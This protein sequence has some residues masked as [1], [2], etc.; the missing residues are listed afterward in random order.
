MHIK[1][2]SIAVPLVFLPLQLLTLHLVHEIK[3]RLVE[4]MHTHITVFSTRGISRALGVNADGVERPEVTTHTT[5]FILEDLVVETGFEFTLASGGGGDIHGSLTTTENHVVFLGGDDGA[6]E[7]GVGNVGFDDGEVTGGN[8]LYFVS[9]F[10]L[11]P[12]EWSLPGAGCDIPW[13]SCLCW[14]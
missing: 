14:Q 8:E 9:C 10:I 13:R 1:K 6:V 4:V 2:S 7:G 3:V 5:D 11:L 12:Y